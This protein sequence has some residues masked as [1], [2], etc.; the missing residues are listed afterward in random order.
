MSLSMVGLSF[1]AAVLLSAFAVRSVAGFGAGLIAIPMLALILPASTAVAVATVFTTFTSLHQAGRDWRH[2]AWRQFVVIFMY[3]IIG[4]GLGLYCIKKLDE[5]MLRHCLGAF[6]ILYSLYALRAPTA[7]RLLPRRWHGAL[8]AAVEIVGGL[9]SALFGAGA[10]PIYVVYFDILR[11]E[12]AV[13]RATMSAVVV[14]GG[15]ARVA[16]YG[17]YGFYGRSTI[18]LL[19]VGLPLV[20]AGSWLGDRLVFRLSARSF[21]RL[22]GGI[23]LL[24]GVTLL[25]R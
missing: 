19:A 2:I 17:S 6:F 23:I 4:I 10:G 24:S 13:F 7:P 1:Y 21:S 22:I 12:R 11:L 18:V 25:V 15:V 14:L 20:I 9:F 3:S 16:G 5:G 8:A